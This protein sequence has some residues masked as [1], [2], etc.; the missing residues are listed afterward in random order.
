MDRAPYRS[1]V[2]SLN[3]LA[4]ATRPGIAFKFA[5]IR[6][7]TIL[8]LLHVYTLAFSRVLNTYYTVSLFF[9]P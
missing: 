6:L 3:Y 8:P 2:D 7:V 1:V 5:V 9:S 4:V